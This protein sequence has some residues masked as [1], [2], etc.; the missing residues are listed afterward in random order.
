MRVA[1]AA[2]GVDH[3]L[4][5]GAVGCAGG[6]GGGSDCLPVGGV[7]GCGDAFT[8]FLAK[9]PGAIAADAT[10]LR[11]LY[12]EDLVPLESACAQAGCGARELYGSIV[13][14]SLELY[15]DVICT[16]MTNSRALSGTKLR[17][18]SRSA[19]AQVTD[20]FGAPP[21]TTFELDR[22]FQ[23]KR[24][25]LMMTHPDAEGH[26]QL[27]CDEVAAG[28][29]LVNDLLT[30]TVAIWETDEDAMDLLTPAQ[31]AGYITFAYGQ[32]HWSRLP[33]PDAMKLATAEAIRGAINDRIMQF[34]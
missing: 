34:G 2:G 24:A 33:L 23:D 8:I 5:S 9:S 3:C 21:A 13:N 32:M 19:P 29:A 12:T 1:G 25:A 6:A 14:D 11:R 26:A 16:P 17:S 18:F 15:T 20:E 31:L 30:H 22:R 28:L 4:P 10:E 7:P 27:A